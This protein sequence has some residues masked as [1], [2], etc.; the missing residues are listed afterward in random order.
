MIGDA[1]GRLPNSVPSHSC[2]GPEQSLI[3]VTLPNS[4]S[5]L[6]LPTRDQYN[7]AARPPV[8]LLFWL[9][10]PNLSAHF[11]RGVYVP[12]LRQPQFVI[13]GL[14]LGFSR[15]TQASFER[16]LLDLY[17]SDLVMATSTC[18]VIFRDHIQVDMNA[19]RTRR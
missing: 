8:G 11:W 2:T 13:L 18:T 4:R 10:C 3:V 14:A 19:R 15:D 6:D 17:K 12:Q 1:E 16:L 9:G 7:A 5:D